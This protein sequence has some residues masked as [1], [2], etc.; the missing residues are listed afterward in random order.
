MEKHTQS[1]TVEIGLLNWLCAL[2][3]SK[4]Y[5]FS[6]AQDICRRACEFELRH[7]PLITQEQAWLDS[8]LIITEFDTDQSAGLATALYRALDGLPPERAALEQE[9]QWAKNRQWMRKPSS[10]T[11]MRRIADLADQG[12]FTISY[13]PLLKTCYL[14]SV[15]EMVLSAL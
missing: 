12:P 2:L 3:L 9:L 6:S 11:L 7:E 4:D 13:D 5:G 10:R 14:M 1:G 15:P 8:W